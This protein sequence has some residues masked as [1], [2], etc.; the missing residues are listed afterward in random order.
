[1]TLRASNLG[2]LRF[3][4]IA[5][6]GVAI[7]GPCS[8]ADTQRFPKLFVATWGTPGP[9]CRSDLAHRF[10]IAP[11]QAIADRTVMRVVGIRIL[12]QN[13]VRV[14]F[15]V[16]GRNHIETLTVGTTGSRLFRARKGRETLIYYHCG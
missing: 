13:I 3:I 6:L 10:E 2:T 16:A 4:A 5:V 11:T 12:A 8:A 9:T 15:S 1:M 7:A 14:S